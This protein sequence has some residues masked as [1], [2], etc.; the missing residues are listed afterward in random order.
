[1]LF[2]SGTFL[3][4]FP[5][6]VLL[7]YLVPKRIKYIWLLLASYF[8]YMG[9]NAKYAI[10]IAVS[11]FTTWGSAILLSK[12]KR[13]K[14]ILIG[15]ICLNLAI[16]FFFKY[17]DF[18]LDNLNWIFSKVGIQQCSNPFDIILPVGIS[19]YTFQALGYIIDVYKGEI[20]AEKNLF[21]YALFVSFFP[22]LVAGPI[23]RSK[24]LLTQIQTIEDNCKA[25]Y[26]RIVNGL[27]YML[28]GL[29]LKMVVADRLAIMVDTVFNDYE[30]YGGVELVFAA[31]G[32]SLQIYFDFSSY[33]IIAIGAAQVLGITLMENF[34]TPYFAVSV[35][36]FW[37]RWHISLSAWMRDYIYI[38]LG[39][40]RK[41][42]FRR[43]VN[44]MI[45]FLVSGL[46]HG[47]NWTYIVWGGYNALLQIIGSYTE[48]IREKIYPMVGLKKETV[49]FRIL[50]T[51]ATNFFILGGM[52]IFR[53][54]SLSDSIKYMWHIFSRWNPW[55]I[56]QDILISFGL[57]RYEWTILLISLIVVFLVAIIKENTG[58][59]IDEFIHSQG[60]FVKCTFFIVLVCAIYVYGIYGAG[61]DASQFIYFQF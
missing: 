2:N 52:I 34:N 29:F 19:F 60:T 24:N 53:S 36:D 55:T 5:T 58:K 59:R 37:S 38:P 30:Y 22:Q 11:T 61:F 41:G 12:M 49:S 10:L 16:L 26:N 20:S 45:S 54:K 57:N 18:F 27:I 32:F 33:S 15:C 35:K 42:R 47:A 9:W 3:V 14:V 48:G 44:L 4:F 39:G 51:I 23:E 21:R 17:F 56:K 25:E 1:M 31:V 50:S 46:W 8:F 13:R 28:Y 40:N 6:V 7:Y 43:D